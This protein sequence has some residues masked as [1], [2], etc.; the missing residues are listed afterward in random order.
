MI[1][2]F[3]AR[4][5]PLGSHGPIV[6]FCFDDFPRTAL[7]TGGR[8]LKSFGVAGTYYVA[9]GLM[10]KVNHLGEQFHCEDLDSLLVD[11]H[12]LASHT[13]GHISC[14]SVSPSTFLEDVQ[15]GRQAIEQLTG[16]TDSGNF[17][18]PFGDFTLSA[19]RLVGA[20]AASC[21]STWKGLNGPD[22]DLNLLRANSLYGGREECT[23]VRKLILENERK[24]SWLIFYSHD[25]QNTPSQYGCTPALLEFAVSCALQTSAHVLTVAEAVASLAYIP[26]QASD[27]RTTFARERREDLSLEGSRGANPQ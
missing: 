1:S 16:T 25:V 4:R 11:G 6:S 27:A 22:V 8:I 14:R 15:K 21:R 3:Y 9:M 18:F 13:Y 10:D 17:A 26:E 20:N 23:L 5:V 7:R 12:E 24:K 19:K 2:R